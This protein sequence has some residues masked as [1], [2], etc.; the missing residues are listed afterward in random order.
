MGPG[1]FGQLT[2]DAVDA[3]NQVDVFLL[4]DSGADQPDLVWL[5]SELLRRHVAHKHRVITVLDRTSGRG[6]DELDEATVETYATIIAGLDEDTC[7]GFLSWGD[8]ALYDSILRTIDALQQRMS[9]RVT[10]CP[11]ISAP[12]ALAAMHQIALTSTGSSLHFTNGA[13]LL[14]QYDPALGDFVVLDDPDLACRG[15]LVEFPDVEL[16]WGAYLGTPD[17]VL[18][19]GPLREVI[20]DL[21]ELRAK[22]VAHHGWIHDTYL[23]RP[24]GVQ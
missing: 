15:L 22:L 18:A 9:L 6:A 7:V 23:L 8:P 13:L 2:L 17:Q 21:V 19:N 4:A 24:P 3:M 16:Y 12:Q 10:V 1:G 20:D 14:E 5:R 11:G